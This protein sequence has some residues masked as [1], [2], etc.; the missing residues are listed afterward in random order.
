[1]G[2]P[3]PVPTGTRFAGA[4]SP[5]ASVASAASARWPRRRRPRPRRFCC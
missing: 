3:S 5:P 4:Y 2:I 1:V